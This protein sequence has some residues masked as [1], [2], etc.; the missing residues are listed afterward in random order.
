[1]SKRINSGYK[2]KKALYTFLYPKRVIFLPSAA[3]KWHYALLKFFL[4]AP[5]IFCAT[6]L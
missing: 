4:K 1:M 6:F 3:K 5:A 2:F